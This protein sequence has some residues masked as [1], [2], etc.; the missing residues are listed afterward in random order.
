M[1]TTLIT[2][3]SGGIGEA[4]AN[5]LAARKHNLLL[6]ARNV[7]KLQLLCIQLAEKYGIDAQFIAVD[8]SKNNSAEIVFKETQKRG[9]HIEVLINNA[10]IGS[11]GAFSELNLQSEL[12]MIQLNNASLVAMTHLF[13]PQMMERKMGTIINVASMAAFMPVPYMAVYAASKVFVRSFTEALVHECKPYNIHVMLLCPG[14]TTTNFNQAAGIEN[15]KG[16][17][18]TAGASLQ[19]PEQVADEALKALDKHKN[20][21][22]SGTKNRIGAKMT[23]FFPNRWIAKFTAENYR[24]AMKI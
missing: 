18:L 13:M 10:G 2:G 15:E 14:L 8:L 19:T 11:G 4:I 1:K 9:L 16:K 6:I 3:A 12:D 23:V 22:I 24:K 5:K 21:I 20:F 7:E 17:A